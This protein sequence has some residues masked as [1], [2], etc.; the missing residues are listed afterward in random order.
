MSGANWLAWRHLRH[1]R[2]RAGLLVVAI[3]IT[4]TLPALVHVL[5][6]RYE[7][8]LRARA[9][10]TP[11]VLGA[12]GNRFDLVLG[13]LYFRPGA[14]EPITL[15][16]VKQIRKSGLGQAFPLHTEF[17]ADGHPLVGTTLDYLSFRG[18]TPVQ[19]RM[20]GRLGEAV[21]GSQI[22]LSPGDPLL[23]DQQD[24][25]DLAATYPLRLD[26][27]GRLAPTGTPDDHAIFVDVRTTWIV[28][29][30][31]HGH[32]DL[33]KAARADERTVVADPSLVQ[34]QHITDENIARFHLH[35]DKADLPLTAVVVA[36]NDQKSQTLLKARYATGS[37]QARIPSE[38]IDELLGVVLR[39]RRFLNT[40][41][42]LITASTGALLLLI[43]LLM[44]RARRPELE[45]L[46]A[47]GA[48]DTFIRRVILVEW[49]ILIGVG[50]VL[51][52]ALI[53]I[54][55]LVAPTIG[56]L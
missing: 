37:V 36:P 53:A 25:Y 11:I 21:V 24:L 3:T 33:T 41:F 10:A 1:H 50:L 42:V 19:G 35:G 43:A 8:G 34:Y 18:L 14:V 39:V 20:I 12:P 9:E 7:A 28:A 13:A 54:G 5:V 49:G 40:H 44:V 47:L 22:D 4:I 2:G 29:G 56:Q 6:G 51:S 26:V 48:T 55:V 32:T 16:P 31:G 30:I 46:R 38:V 45:T 17:T 23:T 27:V 52:G 15:K